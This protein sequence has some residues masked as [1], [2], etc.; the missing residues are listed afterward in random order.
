MSNKLD[1]K[2]T[3]LAVQPRIRLMRSF[4]Q[5]SHSYLGY[6]LRIEGIIGEKEG[7]FSVGIGQAAQAKHKFRA[8]GRAFWTGGTCRRS[9]NGTLR[10]L[11]GQWLEGCRLRC[12]ESIFAPALVRCSDRTESLPRARASTT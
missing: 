1:W 7:V 2:G 5:C 3:L 6:V 4:D 12:G 11:Q 9:E 10:L 8:G